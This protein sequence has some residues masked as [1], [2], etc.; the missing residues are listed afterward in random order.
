MLTEN[1]I[2]TNLFLQDIDCLLNLGEV[3]NIFAID[4]KQEILEL[5]RLA[6]QGGNRNAD[7]SPIQV[8]SFF[9]NR[10]K[11]RLHII[12]CFSPIGNSFRTRV[13]LYPSLVNCCTIDWF[14]SWPEDALEM[15]ANK[16]LKELD[17]PA[18]T[19]SSIVTACKC[20]HIDARNA[21][22]D[23][24]SETG[25]MTY[26]TSASYLELIRSYRSLIGKKQN[27]LR[28]GKMRYIGGLETLE[29]AA[30]AVAKMQI[31][32][33]DL[34]PKLVVLAE[35]SRVMTAEI[36]LKTTEASIAT[37]QVKKDEIIANIQAEAATE[38]K[39][40]CEKDLAQAIP[41]LEEAIGALNTLKPTDIIIVKSMKNPPETVKL[42]MAAVCVIKGITPDR[43]TDTATGKKVFDYWGPSKKLLGDMQFL[44]SLKD[45]DKDN[46]DPENM[47]KI[48]KDYIPHPSFKPE[49]VQKASSAAEG[50]C[51]WIIAMDMYDEVA[52]V[53]APKKARLE[54]AEREFSETMR[55]LVEKKE[56]AEQLAIKVAKL[57]EEL[58]QAN[59]ARQKVED[60]AER[61]ANKLSR[62]ETLI[63]GLGGE[64]SR[65][66]EAA[67]TLQGL[68]DNLPGDILISCG[69]IA[70]LAPFIAQYRDKYCSKWHQLCLQFE[71]PCSK[72]FHFSNVLGSGIT[73]Q[74]WN[75]FGLPR[76]IFSAENGVIMDNSSRFSLFIDPQN[77]ANK[78]IKY[79][80][81]QNDVR[82]LKF[83]QSDY[84]KVCL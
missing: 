2:T 45:F 6:A 63:G 8:F 28:T 47:K 21:S 14:E 48:R 52:K 31:E 5:V 41:V 82:V 65:W 15:V 17:S 33:N 62:A 61:C 75:L 53:V 71:I 24:Y 43:V 57:M 73:I 70:Y 67:F 40:E 10:C 27:E 32:L 12:L 16:A 55:I 23:F 42:V 59:T 36:E 46:I 77:Q 84:M 9:I 3:P 13:R 68:F 4:E 60:E 64:K 50:L 79:M 19:K 54:A 39:V 58:D 29:E 26:V 22:K 81:K 44:Q 74:Q 66:T 35:Q 38:L 80:E 72:E 78:W 7:V 83:S 18:E 11:Q 25:R 20:F 37:E 49:I 30:A 56:M 51:K 34:A 1:Q 69:I 76:D